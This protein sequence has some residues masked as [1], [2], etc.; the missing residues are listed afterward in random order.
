MVGTQWTTRDIFVFSIVWLECK[1]FNNQGEVALEYPDYCNPF[2]WIV[3]H[4]QGSDIVT[5]GKRE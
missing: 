4:W 1:V 5:E 2:I 3:S